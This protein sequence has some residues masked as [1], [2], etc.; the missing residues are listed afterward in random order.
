M[1]T[2]TVVVEPLRRRHLRA[3]MGIERVVY[4]HPWTESL[5]QSELALPASRVYLVARADRAVVGYGGIM[6]APDEAHVTTI[7]VHPEWQRRGVA[8]RVC[9]RHSH[10]RRSSAGSAR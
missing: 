3:V 4:P 7:A 5:F 2:G 8:T 9:S 10:A 6:L 1:S